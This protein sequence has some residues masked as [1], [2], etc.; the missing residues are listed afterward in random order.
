M[1]KSQAD[2]DRELLGV[3]KGADVKTIRRAHRRAVA[4]THPDKFANDPIKRAHA[5]RET[6]RYNIAADRLCNPA[7]DVPKAR[8]PKRTTQHRKA[9][10]ERR[11]RSPQPSPVVQADV[12]EALRE[13]L[14]K[15]PK[16]AVYG[17][18][19][20]IGAKVLSSLFE[21]R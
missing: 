21:E 5:E 17:A 10:T 7:P 9:P 18:A 4:R 19:I 11:A 8:R 12:N 2:L 1:A 15:H 6:K 3:E 16:V 13:L 20:W 14:R